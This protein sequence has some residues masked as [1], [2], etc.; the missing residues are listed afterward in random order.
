M[1]LKY[2]MI[3]LM[4]LSFWMHFYF[5]PLMTFKLT[6]I[7]MSTMLRVIKHF[8]YVKKTLQLIN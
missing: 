7:W 6:V 5:A 4:K 1:G 8:L 2:L 3:L